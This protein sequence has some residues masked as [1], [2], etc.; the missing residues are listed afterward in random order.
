MMVGSLVLLRWTKASLE[1]DDAAG[2]CSWSWSVCRCCCIDGARGKKKR[3]RPPKGNLLAGNSTTNSDVKWFD[4]KFE[5][6]NCARKKIGGKTRK[7]R[8]RRRGDDARGER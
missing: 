3:A 5:F 6:Q 7:R 4:F 8:E 2:G 1:L